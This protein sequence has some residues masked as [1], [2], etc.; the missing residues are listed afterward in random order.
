MLAAAAIPDTDLLHIELT[1]L[2]NQAYRLLDLSQPGSTSFTASLEEANSWLEQGY[3]HLRAAAPPHQPR[4]I[5]TGHS[6]IDMAWLWPL[7]QTRRKA[8]RTFYGAEAHGRIP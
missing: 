4:H 2:L 6:H 7:W 5:V 3:R 8:A 1:N